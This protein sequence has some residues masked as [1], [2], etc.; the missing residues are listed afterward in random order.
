M[1]YCLYGLS[2]LIFAIKFLKEE[3]SSNKSQNLRRSK[4]SIQLIKQ[5][6]QLKVIIISP[7]L[8]HKTP[9]IAFKCSLIL[10][11]HI[12]IIRTPTLKDNPKTILFSPKPNNNTLLKLKF[13]LRQDMLTNLCSNNPRCILSNLLIKVL[14]STINLLDGDYFD[15][16]KRTTKLINY[17]TLSFLFVLNC[18]FSHT[19]LLIKIIFC[20]SLI[21]KFFHLFTFYK[22]RFSSYFQLN[23]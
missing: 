12:L 18:Q 8:L 15:Y 20:K 13:I 22:F 16:N 23:F 6:P 3:N 10:K 17:T 14:Q 2:L 7:K 21:I 5:F 4:F 1:L 11:I 19:I 9:I